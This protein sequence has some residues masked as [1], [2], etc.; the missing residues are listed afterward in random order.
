MADLSG[1]STDDLMALQSGNLSKVSTAGLQMLQGMSQGATAAPKPV[2]PLDTSSPDFKLKALQDRAAMEKEFDPNKDYHWLERIGM[3]GAA[4]LADIY[5][6]AKQRL[7]YATPEETEEKRRIDEKLTGAT[8]GGKFYKGLA[9]TSPYLLLGLIPGMQGIAGGALLGGAAGALTPT[10]E[11]ES[12]VLNTALGAGLGA[13]IPG[14]IQAAKW[15]RG[16]FGQGAAEKAAN[17]AAQ[18]V[19]EE[20]GGAATPGNFVSRTVGNVT[21]STRRNQQQAAEAVA[22][23]LRRA[24]PTPDIAGVRV[25]L[26]AGQELDNPAWTR[27]EAGNR[28]RNPNNWFDFTRSQKQG[29][30]DAAEAATSEA[31]N[32]ARLR[33]NRGTAY[34]QG[35]AEAMQ[36]AKRAPEELMPEVSQ[37]LDAIEAGRVGPQ[38]MRPGVRPFYEGQASNLE[39]VGEAITPEHLME[40]RTA[41]NA[42]YSHPGGRL[43]SKDAAITDLKATYDEVLDRLTEGRATPVTQQFAEASRGVNEAQAAANVRGKFWS[44]EGRPLTKTEFGDVPTI[45]ETRL[46]DAIEAQANEARFGGGTKLSPETARNLDALLNTIRKTGNVQE[47]NKIATGGGGSATAANQF[48]ALAAEEAGN[49]MRRMMELKL[50][51]AGKIATGAYDIFTKGNAAKADALLARA[52]QDPT[53]RLQMMEQY[54]QSLT[55]A[56]GNYRAVVDALRSAGQGYAQH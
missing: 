46:R 26:S 39:N 50:G 15:A 33:Q 54:A 52:L 37:I 9:N 22:D 12:A 3:S 11:G 14:G 35:L 5:Q 55:P 51:P 53:F 25:P 42:G 7:G 19:A 8:W 4:G 24:Q 6:G 44:P 2:R 48:H 1:F 21:G 41:L 38:S 18:Q 31:E 49:A 10:G 23:E 56:S 36:H 45:T 28:I 40:A 47:L 30:A 13:A 29:I 34:E 27:L 43:S 16:T 32:L 20:V 17:A